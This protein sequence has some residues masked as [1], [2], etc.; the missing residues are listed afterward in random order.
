MP[1]N[2]VS[3]KIKTYAICD[4]RGQVNGMFCELSKSRSKNASALKEI[5]IYLIL[6]FRTS[7]HI[8]ALDYHIH[9]YF[10]VYSLAPFSSLEMCVYV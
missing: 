7:V 2:I 4:T 8:R 1:M 5:S 6:F 3:V 10:L 9:L